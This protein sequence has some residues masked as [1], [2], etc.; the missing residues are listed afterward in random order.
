MYLPGAYLLMMHL[1][2]LLGE[3]LGV[4]LALFPT[5]YL[6]AGT[7]TALILVGGE[8]MKLFFQIV[9]GPLCSS[10]PLTTVEWYLVFTSLCIV[11]SQLPNLNSI[12][13]LSLVGAVTAITYSTMVWVLSVSQ[14][15]PPSLSYQP[16][17]LPTLTASVFSVLN[18]LGI[19]AFAFRGH[20]LVLEIQVCTIF[21]MHMLQLVYTLC[22]KWLLYESSYYYI[23]ILRTVA[24]DIF[25]GNNAI[26]LQETSSC[27]DVEGSKGCLCLYCYVLVPCC[28][29]R[30][31]GLWKPRESIPFPFQWHHKKFRWKCISVFIT[32]IIYM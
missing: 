6:S 1:L 26:N 17:S 20:N 13:G 21:Y 24:H 31:L 15:R 4:W 9:C 19:I 28:H 25:L 32:I 23:Q 22:F 30:L 12:A 3:R 8:T 2:I 5:V 18:A 11:L 7:A 10:N 27:A 16:V 14:Q 29:W